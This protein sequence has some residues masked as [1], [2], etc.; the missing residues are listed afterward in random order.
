MQFGAALGVDA[1]AA[2]RAVPHAVVVILHNAGSRAQRPHLR[3]HRPPA[4]LLLIR[5][6]DAQPYGAQYSTLSTVQ[7]GGIAV[8]TGGR[9]LP[10][11]EAAAAVR[12]TRKPELNPHGTARHSGLVPCAQVELRGHLA[13]AARRVP[14][15]A[16]ELLRYGLPVRARRRR[17]LLALLHRHVDRLLLPGTSCGTRTLTSTGTITVTY[18]ASACRLA[19]VLNIFLA[20]MI[21]AFTR[22]MSSRRRETAGAAP[23]RAFSLALD[24]L[25]TWWLSRDVRNRVAPATTPGADEDCVPPPP[26]SPRAAEKPSAPGGELQASHDSQ[27][28]DSSGPGPG[29]PTST[30]GS[31]ERPQSQEL[32]EARPAADVAMADDKTSAQTSPVV[33]QSLEA[34]PNALSPEAPAAA[35][36]T[37]SAADTADAARDKR[38]V[39]VEA[40]LSSGSPARSA[41]PLLEDVLA[42]HTRCGVLV[43]DC[44]WSVCSPKYAMKHTV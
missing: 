29:E 32:V 33:V 4:L 43:E 38:L 20:L 34:E 2:A 37:Q 1:R 16:R 30:A 13:L 36:S 10:A 22:S 21:E 41:E 40:A 19:Q 23:S 39:L 8:R 14:L 35:N 44:L 12:A 26:G 28:A 17:P 5:V 9:Q 15:P 11:G 18:C 31:G 27:Q 24:K 6:H 42:A 7:Y 3:H 25:R